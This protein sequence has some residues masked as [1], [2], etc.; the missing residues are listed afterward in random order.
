MAYIPSF[1]SDVSTFLMDRC[2]GSRASMPPQYILVLLKRYRNIWQ[3]L[4]LVKNLSSSY[5]F[6]KYVLDREHWGPF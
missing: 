6:Y 5:D 4:S 2:G 1:L 3:Q